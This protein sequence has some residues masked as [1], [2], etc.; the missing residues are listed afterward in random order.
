MLNWFRTWTQHKPEHN[1]GYRAKS[2]NVSWCAHKCGN[3]ETNIMFYCQQD[4]EKCLKSS[5]FCTSLCNTMENRWQKYSR[6]GVYVAWCTLQLSTWPY[7][8]GLLTELSPN[9]FPWKAIY[10]RECGLLAGILKNM[11]MLEHGNNLRCSAENTAQVGALATIQLRWCVA[12]LTPCT[13]TKVKL[14]LGLR[15]SFIKLLVVSWVLVWFHIGIHHQK[16][17]KNS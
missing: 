14:Y 13:I 6:V 4:A 2:F 11:S 10:H 3:R 9:T 17:N 1:R 7:A 15:Q 8:G 5:I 16:G 12:I